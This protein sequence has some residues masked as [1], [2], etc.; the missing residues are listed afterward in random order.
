MLLED[1]SAWPDRVQW[2]GEAKAS[3]PHPPWLGIDRVSWNCIQ[4]LLEID[5]PSE[6]LTSFFTSRGGQTVLG[7]RSV[8]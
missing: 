7:G 5:F 4:P 1:L 2:V 3:G 6:D 8:S